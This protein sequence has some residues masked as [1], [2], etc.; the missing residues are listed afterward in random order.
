MTK[1]CSLL[2]SKSDTISAAEFDK[3]GTLNEI[4]QGKNFLQS[5]QKIIPNTWLLLDNQSTCDMVTNKDLLTNLRKSDGYLIL[6]M[7]TGIDKTDIIGDMPR[8]WRPIWYSPNVIANILSL[9]N[10]IEKHRVIYNSAERNEFKVHKENGSIRIFK[11]FAKGLYYLDMAKHEKHATLVT[12]VEKNKAKYTN[13]D[14]KH[15]VLARKN[16][17]PYWSSFIQRFPILP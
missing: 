7:Q 14:Y 12:T 6:K 1:L 2:F 5:S 8:Y 9:S 15:A 16:S 13:T 10:I 11:Q 3:H 17:N 4:H